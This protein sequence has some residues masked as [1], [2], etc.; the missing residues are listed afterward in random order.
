MIDSTTIV[1]LTVFVSGLSETPPGAFV[2]DTIF[3]GLATVTYRGNPRTTWRFLR[4]LVFNEG[5]C[6]YVECKAFLSVSAELTA[7]AARTGMRFDTRD[8]LHRG[9][10]T[11]ETLLDYLVEAVEYAPAFERE[12]ELPSL[13]D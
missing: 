12:H 8:N 6:T 13:R 11:I 4:D 3:P 2:N 1:S 9:C 10:F 5:G 7:F